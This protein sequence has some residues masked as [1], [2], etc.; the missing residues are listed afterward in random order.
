MGLVCA[1][2]PRKTQ[3]NRNTLAHSER[4]VGLVCHGCPVGCG[5]AITLR[6]GEPQVDGI[7]QAIVLDDQPWYVKAYYV[8]LYDSRP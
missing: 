4:A 3:V 8:L 7:L 6:Q 5:V 2:K 1:T